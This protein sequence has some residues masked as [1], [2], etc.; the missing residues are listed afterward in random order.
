MNGNFHFP[1]RMM[2]FSDTRIFQTMN[3]RLFI[4]TKRLCGGTRRIKRPPLFLKNLFCRRCL[5]AHDKGVP[6]II[7]VTWLRVY[8]N[9]GSVMCAPYFFT[10]T[11]QQRRG[12]L[13]I[14]HISVDIHP[15][16]HFFVRT[17]PQEKSKRMLMECSFPLTVFRVVI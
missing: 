8:S 15:F 2:D 16:I 4:K 3:T 9:S 17:P 12:R 14:M 5:S 13:F 11:K 10:R 1:W 7:I 6:I